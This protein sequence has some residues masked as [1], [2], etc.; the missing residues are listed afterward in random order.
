MVLK[1]VYFTKDFDNLLVLLMRKILYWLNDS[2]LISMQNT[3]FIRVLKVLVCKIAPGQKFHL[4]FCRNSKP[5]MC[6]TF[7]K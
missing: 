4:G 3:E 5:N 2:W 1:L 6:N 7:I